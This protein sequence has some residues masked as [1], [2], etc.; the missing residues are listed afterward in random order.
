MLELSRKVSE[1]KFT[2]E[3]ELETILDLRI[4]PHLW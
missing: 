3:K 1:S 2:R 4:H